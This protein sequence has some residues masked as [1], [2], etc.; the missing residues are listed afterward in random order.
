MRVDLKKFLFV[1]LESERESF[2]QKLQE[3]G[4]VHVININP[5]ALKGIPTEVEHLTAAIKVLRGLPTVEQEET[6]E[7]AI[8]DGFAEKIIQLKNH[9]EKLEEEGRLNKLEISRVEVFGDF[10]Q[11]NID[12]VQKEGNRFIQFFFS[13]SGAYEHEKLPDGVI[14]VGTEHGLDYFVS[15]QKE[16]SQYP[17][18]NEMQIPHPLGQLKNRQAEIQKDYRDTDMH[19]KGYSKYNQFL[20]HALIQKLNG[21]HLD[22]AKNSVEK[23]AEGELFAFEGWV[24][25]NKV[26]VLQRFVGKSHVFL[27]EVAIEADDKIPTCLE[28]QGMHRIGEDLVHIYDTPSHTDKDP[29]IWVLIFFSIFFGMVIGDGGY[30]LV[31]L[32]AA[33]Y[34]RYKHQ[35]M[36]AL[37]L[38]IWKLFVILSLTSIAWGLFSSSFFGIHISQENPIRKVSV[39]NWLIN[40][41]AEYHFARQ[42]TTY[43]SWV[44]KFPDLK[45]AHNAKEFLAGA[46]KPGDITQGSQS[47]MYSRFAD[48]IMMEIALLIGVIHIIIS[49]LRYLDRNWSGVG[50]IIFLVGSYLYIPFFLGATSIIHFVF[51]VSEKWGEQN[52]LYLIAGGITLALILA[53]I[54]N[55]IFGIFEGMH[56]IQIFADVMSYLRLYALGLAGAMVMATIN[57]FAAQMTFVLGIILFLIGHLTNMALGIMG[58]I[59]H[60]LRLNFLE[61]YH[62]SFEGGGK[63][64]DPLHLQKID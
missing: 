64:Y 43:T 40:K 17:R 49:F 19:L 32:A 44:S 16:H 21:Y 8:A 20:H 59:I 55:K 24:P 23:P 14:F 25:E 38:R 7:Y 30:G 63:P 27:E 26:E 47:E 57:E 46:K 3:F 29:S 10:S 13:K 4:I 42:D 33:I 39:L 53:V 50:W 34:I 58:G 37:G 36:K 62:Y 35:S 22:V 6:S 56:V 54:K 15:I 11:K 61:W 60:G 2:F 28:N 31:F 52:G 41:K 51:G 5:A 48:N 9:L 45:N 18:M 1:G 12:F